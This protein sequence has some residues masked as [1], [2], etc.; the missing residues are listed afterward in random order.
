[1]TLNYTIWHYNLTQNKFIKLQK[2]Y[3]PFIL[4][5]MMLLCGHHNCTASSSNAKWTR[6]THLLWLFFSWQVENSM[7]L[8]VAVEFKAFA[9]WLKRTSAWFFIRYKGKLPYTALHREKTLLN[10]LSSFFLICVGVYKMCSYQTLLKY[11]KCRC[12][13]S[14]LPTS[15][16]KNIFFLNAIVQPTKYP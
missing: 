12:A 10:T 13:A 8:L 5:L 2:N 3:Q 4:I 6:K 16:Q 9:T 14:L 7:Q 15:L 11:V 1:L